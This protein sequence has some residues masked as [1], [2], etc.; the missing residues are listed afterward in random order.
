MELEIGKIVLGDTGMDVGIDVGGGYVILE[1]GIRFKKIEEVLAHLAKE[2]VFAIRVEVDG[3]LEHG[4]EF[5]ES[6]W[7]VIIRQEEGNKFI[8]KKG[9]KKCFCSI[10]L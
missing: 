5:V 7:V 6:Y 8:H 2:L 3:I 1:D 9:P 4:N 10:R